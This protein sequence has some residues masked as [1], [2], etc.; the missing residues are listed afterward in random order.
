M[1]KV[2]KIMIILLALVLITS[3]IYVVIHTNNKKVKQNKQM[4]I[5]EVTEEQLRNNINTIA[6]KHTNKHA[7]CELV[8]SDERDTYLFNDEVRNKVGDLGDLDRIVFID[9]SIVNA[10]K[11]DRSYKEVY[12]IFESLMYLSNKVT[13]F[14]IIGVSC[15]YTSGGMDNTNFQLTLVTTEEFNSLLSTT[16]ITGLNSEQ[17]AEVIAN[18]WIEDIGYIKK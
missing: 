2:F 11:I 15:V 17:A 18:K 3:G 9:A 10:F 5:I 14:N 8:G 13:P 16:D 12:G 7:F 4:E 6:K 1:N